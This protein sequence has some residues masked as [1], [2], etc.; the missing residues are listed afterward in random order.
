MSPGGIM[1]AQYDAFAWQ[2]HPGDRPV[3]HSALQ[4]EGAG[5]QIYQMLGD[6]QAEA[7]AVGTARHHV[8]DLRKWPEQFR[9]ITRRDPDAAVRDGEP[10]GRVGRAAD[11]VLERSFRASR[12]DLLAIGIGDLTV[13][14]AALWAKR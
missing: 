7:G 14:C 6:H 9:Q 4:L 3:A 2:Q 5:M 10:A 11:A 1:I 13:G 12:Y 8:A